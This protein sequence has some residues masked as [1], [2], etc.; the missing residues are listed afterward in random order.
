[1]DFRRRLTVYRSDGGSGPKERGKSISSAAEDSGHSRWYRVR[2]ESSE[3]ELADVAADVG[4]NDDPTLPVGSETG[5]RRVAAGHAVVPD[6]CMTL[7]RVDLSRKR[8]PTWFCV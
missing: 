5:E 4:Q 1:M 8:E 6:D 3:C 2:Q 7:P